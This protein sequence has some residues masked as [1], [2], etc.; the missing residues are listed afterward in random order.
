M[1]LSAAMLAE[2]QRADPHWHWVLELGDNALRYAEGD[3][4]STSRGHYNGQ[5]SDGAGNTGL[6]GWSRSRSDR[7]YSLSATPLTVTLVDS[8]LGIAKAVGGYGSAPTIARG[9]AAT[10]KLA[11]PR[12]TPADWWTE[13]TGIVETFSMSRPRVWQFSLRPNDLPLARPFPR[14]EYLISRAMFPDAPRASYGQM[15]PIVYGEHDST[16]ST[17]SGAV[18]GIRVGAG[19]Y[20]FSGHAL[21]V[22]RVYVDGE[23]QDSALWAASTLTRGV[24]CK[25]VTFDADSD[26]GE[27]AVVTADVVATLTDPVDAIEDVLDTWVYGSASAPIDATSFA[28]VKSFLASV[29]GGGHVCSRRISGSA[30][31]DDLPTGEQIVNEWCASLGVYATWTQAGQIALAVDDHRSGTSYP[32]VVIRPEDILAFSRDAQG[33]H[34]LSVGYDVESVIDRASVAFLPI[35]GGYRETLQVR[36]QSISGSAAQSQISMAWSRA[37]VLA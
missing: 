22:N 32:T 24:A 5:I 23:L 26:P 3:F 13:W 27:A 11:S 31:D 33:A 35:A 1:A 20:L 6:Q 10:L 16:A 28:A 14:A 36:D 19:I 25:V 37:Q 4:A 29:A 8:D 15:M 2:L 30:T 21:T 7:A 12:V 17:G 34:D 18:E 9:S